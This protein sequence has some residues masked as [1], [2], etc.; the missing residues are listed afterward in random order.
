[1]SMKRTVRNSLALLA[2][3]TAAPWMLPAVADHPGRY[4]PSPESISQNMKLLRSAP[5]TNPASFYRNSD[6]VFCGQ[7]TFAGN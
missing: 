1:M 6:L 7:L 4:I 2:F 5:K 3:L